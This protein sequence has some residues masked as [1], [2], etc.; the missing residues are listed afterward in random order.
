MLRDDARDRDGF[1]AQLRRST[2]AWVPRSSRGRENTPRTRSQGGPF[3]EGFGQT[4]ASNLLPL[5]APYIIPARVIPNAKRAPRDRVNSH[6][7]VGSAPRT[8][9][10]RVVPGGIR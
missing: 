4:C 10:P 3:V 2:S 7:L 6:V 8:A 1:V 5:P 9:R